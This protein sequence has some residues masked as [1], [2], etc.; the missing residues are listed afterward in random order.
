MEESLYISHEG[1]TVDPE[2]EQDVDERVNHVRASQEK[3]VETDA[4]HRR[5]G[6]VANPRLRKLLFVDVKR[7]IPPWK[8]RNGV[9]VETI[10]LNRCSRFA[11]LFHFAE[12]TFTSRR[13]PLHPWNHVA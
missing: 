13:I 5:S 12:N 2:V 4:A 1:I 11:E 10:D 8:R 3:V 6:V 7:K 9:V